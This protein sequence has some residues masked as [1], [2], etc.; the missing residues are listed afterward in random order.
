MSIATFMLNIDT[1]MAHRIGIQP[2]SGKQRRCPRWGERNTK[3][4][5]GGRTY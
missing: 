2:S 5:G 1:E 3:N 4:G